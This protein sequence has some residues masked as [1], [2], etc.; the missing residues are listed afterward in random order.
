MI[1]K[2]DGLMIRTVSRSYS[3]PSV[4]RL[5]QYRKV[6]HKRIMLTRKNILTRDNHHCQYCDMDARDAA[7][8]S[9]I[10]KKAAKTRAANKKKAAKKTTKKKRKA[11]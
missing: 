11:A 3:L 7:A 10:A 8:R 9:A 5:W 1:E 4:V 6:P 2:A